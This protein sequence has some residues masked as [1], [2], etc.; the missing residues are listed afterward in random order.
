MDPKTGEYLI[1]DCYKELYKS[2]ET[3]RLF[4]HRTTEYDYMI[5]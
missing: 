1:L 3:N 4:I 2:Y 5:L